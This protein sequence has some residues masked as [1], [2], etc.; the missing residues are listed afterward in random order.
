MPDQ[1]RVAIVTCTAQGLGKA[2]ALRLARDGLSIGLND[3]PSKKDALDEV[4]RAITS[5]GGR[6]AVFLGDV[7]KQEDVLAIIDGTL[8]VLGG[9]HVMVANA[10]IARPAPFLEETLES[11]NKVTS[12]SATGV[13]L[14][15]QLAARKMIELGH[16]EGRL[17]GASSIGCKQPLRG[18]TS[19]TAAKFAVRGLTQSAALALGTHGITV[20]AY[21]PVV[22]MSLGSS[23]AYTDKLDDYTDLAFDM[24]LPFQ[25]SS[26]SPLGR[27]GQ[28]EEVASLVSFLASKESGF[29]TG[30]LDD[31]IS[32][33][34]GAHMD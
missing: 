22:L 31:A 18:L 30:E 25:K 34:G 23:V 9:L 4:G 19:Y 27:C 7:S 13:F 28:P 12:V 26:L 10:G 11:F 33:D 2:I 6:A 3:I 5:N 32:I 8:E 15:Y 1:P 20:N 17:I 24:S 21:A 14:C 29:I 16:R